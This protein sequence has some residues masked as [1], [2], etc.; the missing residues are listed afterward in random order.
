MDTYSFYFHQNTEITWTRC[1]IWGINLKLNHSVIKA[2]RWFIYFSL[3][4]LRQSVWSGISAQTRS[5]GWWFSTASSFRNNESTPGLSLHRVWWC[6]PGSCSPD[7]PLRLAGM[8][9]TSVPSVGRKLRLVRGI[10]LIK[11]TQQ[12]GGPRRRSDL[13]SGEP[14]G[15]GR[16]HLCYT[17][18]TS[19]GRGF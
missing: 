14:V 13:F 18:K 16:Q 4:F 15:L 19:G 7:F 9:Q 3:I 5:C 6:G 2:E 17:V 10:S 11:K 1:E 12:C 8:P